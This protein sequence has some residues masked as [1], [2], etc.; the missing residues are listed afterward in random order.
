MKM[1]QHKPEF[2][3]INPNGKVPAISDKSGQ[4]NLFESHAILR[5]LHQTRSTSDNWYPKDPLKRAKVDE[6][7]DWHHNGLRLGAS[8]Y[9]FHKYLQPFSGKAA[10]KE[11]VQESYVIFQKAL[12]LMET[13]WLKDTPYLNG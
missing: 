10:P 1:D 11:A 12:F 3:K 7:L 2:K 4:I 5:Y 6:Y 13:Y 8:G 9:L